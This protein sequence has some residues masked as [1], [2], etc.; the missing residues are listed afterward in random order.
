[1]GIPS[2]GFNSSPCHRIFFGY[3]D[4]VLRLEKKVVSTFLP[5]DKNYGVIFFIVPSVIVIGSQ[6]GDEGKGKAIDVFSASAD[7]VVR[8]Q[9]GAN[10][11]HTLNIQGEKKVL[12][13][14]PSGVFHKKCICVISAGVALDIETLVSEIRDIKKSGAYL[15]TPDKLLIS[16]S[17]T[18]LLDYHKTLDRVRESR[19][20]KIGTTGKGIGPAYEDRAGR[21]ALLLADLFLDLPAL[22]E[23]LNRAVAEKTFLLEKLYKQGPVSKEILL[24]QILTLREELRPYRVQDTSAVIHKA[25]KENK[26]VL[27]EGAQGAL[28]DLFY[29]T[30]PYV[31]SC[32]TLAGFALAGGG[33]GPKWVQKVMAITKA[34]TTRVGEGPFPTECSGAEGS[35]LQEKGEEWGATTGRKR[36]CGW[37][38]LLALKYA[39]RLNGVTNMALMK[40]DVLSSVPEIPVCVAYKIKGK[41]QEDYPVLKEELALC[42]PVYHTLPGWQK[43]ISGVK[44]FKNLPLPAQHYVD[45]IQ[46]RVNVPVDMV[47]LGPTRPATLQ[48]SPLF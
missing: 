44:S 48:L 8:Y 6:W 10:A 19:G 24:N 41:K 16:D 2:K 32:S 20:S 39:V 9:G 3:L 36:R 12:H 22:K 38:D 42:E 46:K 34:Y 45:F 1:M 31:T 25:L 33:L 47:S 29:G 37:L 35:L 17:A 11:G 7:Y 27:F 13:L 28:L 40:L 43:D 23:K 18:V 26:K 4:K 21:Q 5:S 14:I 15:D 30:Y